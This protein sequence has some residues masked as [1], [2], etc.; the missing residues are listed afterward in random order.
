M[1][2]SFQYLWDE[3][4]FIEIDSAFTIISFCH[5]SILQ[6]A[7]RPISQHPIVHN[8]D[9]RRQFYFM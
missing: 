6:N 8:L 3:S 5:F 4:S 9:H 2:Q 7:E 1:T